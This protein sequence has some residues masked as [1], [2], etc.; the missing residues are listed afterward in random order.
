MF[1]N[2]FCMSRKSY[3]LKYCFS[4]SISLGFFFCFCFFL[5]ARIT[6]S[7]YSA[8]CGVIKGTSEFG[9]W[10]FMFLNMFAFWVGICVVLLRYRMM[11][12][13]KKHGFL[14]KTKSLAKPFVVNVQYINTY[15]CHTPIQKIKCEMSP[16][17]L[18]S[19]FRF[20]Y[21]STK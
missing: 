3:T 6:T 12:F 5:C 14:Q 20:A 11:H 2:R 8:F 17:P 4:P 19:H 13:T 15:A 1:W 16:A 9:N 18:I 21:Q 7:N 10:F